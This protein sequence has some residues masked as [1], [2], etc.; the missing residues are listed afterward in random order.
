MTIDARVSTLIKDI[1]TAGENP[2][3]WDDVAVRLLQ[4]MGSQ[5][6]V[7]TLVR[8]PRM[9]LL[10]CRV[11]SPRSAG[12]D[13]SEGSYPDHYAE[14]PCL[15]WAS[16]N[17]HARFCDSR[18]I[19]SANADFDHPFQRW[20]TSRLNASHWY[21]GFSSSEEAPTFLFTAFFNKT[22]GPGLEDA[23]NVFRTVFDHMECALRLGRQP[24]V[25]VSARALIRLGT[26]GAIQQLSRGAE[27]L[28]SQ[29]GPLRIAGARLAANSPMEQKNLDQA[30]SRATAGSSSGSGPTAVH[31]GSENGRPWITVVRPVYECF[32][33]FGKVNQQ[34]QLEVF[35]RVPAIGRLD[36]VQ[37]LFNLTGR[38][39]QVLRLLSEGHS[40]DSLS[41]C[42][43]VSR[44]T[45][46]AHLR[47]IYTKTRTSSQTELMQ[48]CAGLSAAAIADLAPANRTSP[49]VNYG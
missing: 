29:R 35:D 14:D 10:S 37:S 28:L 47:S 6:G 4:V 46:R 33:P 17:P 23:H 8:L 9:Q 7:A 38:E 39:L 2:A 15:V 16:I 36:I 25:D 40:I 21:T 24:S 13:D 34:I 32:G 11:Y 19:L 43:T 45:T 3:A 20:A 42:L 18:E 12:L 5:A 30:L 41:A 49:T 22:S 27:A 26:D 48:L 31:L 1:Y 44:N